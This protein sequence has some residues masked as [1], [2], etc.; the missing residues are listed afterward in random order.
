MGLRAVRALT[1]RLIFLAV[2]FANKKNSFSPHYRARGHR[3]EAA[4]PD[5]GG[6]GKSKYTQF[7]V[8][9]DIRE[10]FGVIKDTRFIHTN[11]LCKVVVNVGL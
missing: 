7:G 6:G 1:S 5:P 2:V 10:E 4:L 3:A 8:I 9:Q 11:C